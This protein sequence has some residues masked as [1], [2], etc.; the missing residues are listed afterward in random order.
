MVIVLFFEILRG[1]YFLFV[2]TDIA[3]RIKWRV[4]KA[5]GQ[6]NLVNLVIWSI[7]IIQDWKFKKKCSVFE[8]VSLVR[9]K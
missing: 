1:E 7:F 6:C 8:S 3:L 4:R 9:D 5:Q 2:F